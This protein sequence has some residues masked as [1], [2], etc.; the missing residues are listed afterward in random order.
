MHNSE[1]DEELRLL[2]D[3]RYRNICIDDV[4]NNFSYRDREIAK[5]KFGLGG[6]YTYTNREIAAIFK[7]DTTDI[8]SRVEEIREHFK[9]AGLLSILDLVTR[10]R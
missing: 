2:L 10:Q 6:G 8:E 1:N 7:T 9:N 3:I 4:L 5:F